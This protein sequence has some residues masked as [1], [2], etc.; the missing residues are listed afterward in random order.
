MQCIAYGLQRLIWAFF[1]TRIF[2][3]EPLDCTKYVFFSYLFLG[4]KQLTKINRVCFF[5]SFSQNLV[6]TVGAWD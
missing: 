6:H 1:I 5:D 4:Y 2:S 3:L